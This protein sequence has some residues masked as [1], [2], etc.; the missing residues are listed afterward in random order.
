MVDVGCVHILVYCGFALAVWIEGVVTVIEHHRGDYT[1]EV[2]CTAVTIY[3][4]DSFVVN[5]NL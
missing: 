4:S 5:R 1:R 2:S 3:C